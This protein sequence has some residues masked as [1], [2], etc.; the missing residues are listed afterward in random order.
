MK[1][2]F[3]SSKVGHEILRLLEEVSNPRNELLPNEVS[4]WFLTGKSAKAGFESASRFWF[5][6]T[7]LRM[8]LDERYRQ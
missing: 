4:K 6:R 7:L 8:I 3:S 1:C 2:G 5:R